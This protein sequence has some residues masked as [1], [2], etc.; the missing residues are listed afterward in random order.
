MLHN[1][2]CRPF[3][4][5]RQGSTG[6]VHFVETEKDLEI[7]FNNGTAP[8]YVPVIPTALFDKSLVEKLIASNKVSGL[9]LYRQNDTKIEH[10]THESTCP[11]S[12]SG[13]PGTCDV[14]W[15]P[16]GTDLLNMDV[17]FTIFY[18][19]FDEDVP[20]LKNCFEKFNNFSFETQAE[21]S[22]CAL[23]IDAF[24]YATTDTPTCL[25]LVCIFA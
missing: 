6:V 14:N 20:K 9:V 2:S 25:R 13:L 16:Y 21:R 24:M 1:T 3:L 8:P 15:N 5:N 22:L 11:N 12:K 7:M 4:A 23:E 19:E 17:P 18:L 10:F